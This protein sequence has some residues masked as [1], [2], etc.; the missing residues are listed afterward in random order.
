M[1]FFHFSWLQIKAKKSIYLVVILPIVLV[2]GIWGG[3]Q[4]LVEEEDLFATEAALHQKTGEIYQQLEQEQALTSEFQQALQQFDAVYSQLNFQ[5]YRGKKVQAFEAANQKRLFV[6]DGLVDSLPEV[7]QME[8]RSYRFSIERSQRFFEQLLLDHQPVFQSSKV[9]HTI[10]YWIKGILGSIFVFGFIYWGNEFLREKR[11]KQALYQVLPAK[12]STIF[13][14]Q[15]A[16]NQLIYFVIPSMIFIA[17]ASLTTQVLYG[18]N[19]FTYP[20]D[21]IAANGSLQ[22]STASVLLRV[23]LL[24]QLVMTGV[25][26]LVLSCIAIEDSALLLLIIGGLCVAPMYVTQEWLH[27]LPSYYLVF[28]NL[29]PLVRG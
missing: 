1:N 29:L 19:L 5:F 18:M 17:A 28:W 8:L 15:L 2:I 14:Q 10:E 6:F 20:I 27:W 13:W 21:W 9:F 3:Q 12:K 4:Y 7:F 11:R 16:M 25:I 26:F 22:L 24:Y 23:A